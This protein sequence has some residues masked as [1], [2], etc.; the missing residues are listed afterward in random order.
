[1]V[2]ISMIA[3]ISGI[4]LFIASMNSMDSDK[5]LRN[6][7]IIIAIGGIIGG[8]FATPSR[9][10]P[11]G[12]PGAAML[13]IVFVL[14]GVFVIVKKYIIKKNDKKEDSNKVKINSKTLLVIVSIIFFILVVFAFSSSKNTSRSNEPWK[15][16]GVSEREYM[17]VYNHYKYGTRIK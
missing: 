2:T 6:G 10:M 1:M 13:S 16:L 11:N 8:C 5:S 7:S 3:L 9:D 12:M 17:N 15:D 14:I 4:L